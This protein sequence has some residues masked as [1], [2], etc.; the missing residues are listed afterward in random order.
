[1]TREE[2]GGGITSSAE[3]SHSK[4]WHWYVNSLSSVP[5][6]Q[7]MKPNSLLESVG[8]HLWTGDRGQV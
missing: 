6:L 1:M 4:T 2:V 8:Q 5:L 7:E 3:V